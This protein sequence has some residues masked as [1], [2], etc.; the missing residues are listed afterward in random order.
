[1]NNHILENIQ[2]ILDEARSAGNAAASEYFIKELNSKDAY[3]CGF[4]W[5]EI[6]GVK[7][8]TKLGKYLKLVGVRHNDYNRCFEFHGTDMMVQNMD[9]KYE[10]AKA[11]SAVLRKYGFNAYA[12]ER[13]D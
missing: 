11:A 13:I 2:K 9:V 10:G 12:M 7:G 1:M 5:V 6:H 8:N 4:A 3:P